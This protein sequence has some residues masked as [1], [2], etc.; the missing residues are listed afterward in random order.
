MKR[1]CQIEE[2]VCGSGIKKE[3]K[4]GMADQADSVYFNLRNIVNNPSNRYY[5][6]CLF[7]N[8]C[9]NIYCENRVCDNNKRNRQ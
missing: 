1:Y 9:Y 8:I 2:W 6:M 5:K 7:H 3:L 4:I